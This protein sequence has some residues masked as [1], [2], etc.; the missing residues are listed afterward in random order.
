[1][2]DGVIM[3]S[4]LY[5]SDAFEIVLAPMLWLVSL[6]SF[7]ITG[8]SSGIGRATALLF[9]KHKYQLSLTGRNEAALKDVAKE[10]VQQG[11]TEN[12]LVIS[13]TDLAADDAPK[14]VVHNTLGK[15]QRIDSLVN[16]AG[17]LRAGTVLDSDI[18]VYD[19]LFNVNVRC[20]VRL[21]R[22]ALPHIIKSKGTVVNV[23]SINGPC[24]FPGVTYYCM[25]KSAVD[26]FTKCLALEMAPHGVRVNAV[27]PG[28][29]VTNLHRRSGQDE[30]AYAA[31]LEKS[32]STHALGRPGDPR[33]VAEAIL[34]LASAKS[35]FTTGQLLRVDGGASSG[36][37]QAVS[38]RLA[39]EGYALSLSGRD[40]KAL[41]ETVEQCN[42]AGAERVIIT[43]GDL[44]D[45]SNAER[46]VDNTMKE[47]QRIDTLVNSAGILVTGNV[48]DADL[49]LY[50]RQMDVNVRS[51][52]R[53]TRMALPHII[54]SKGTVVSVSSITGP[55]PFPGVTYYCMSKAALDQFTKCLALEMAPHGV[56]VNAV[57]P[58]VIVTNVHKRAGMDDQSYREFLEKGKSTHA[59]GRVGE[60]CEVA[61]AV[62]FLASEKSSFTTGELLRVDGGR[63]IMHP[64]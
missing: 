21:T 51:V 39:R 12:D 31:F 8:A 29:T 63:G 3:V 10:C 4:V 48:L 24:P 50:D 35:S 46:L 59:L 62:F 64:R 38:V 61:E 33:E 27:N 42:N 20:L 43:V 49:D 55:C 52:V 1:M 54:K 16:S 6:M 22:E 34:F 14:T 32:K 45:D 57:N 30:T 7:S 17:I 56:R 23:S 53:L 11:I 19:E 47:Y 25:S 28:V 60:A 41:M 40:E 9:A 15:F 2:T 44:C 37:G 13:P 26:Q 5:K 18:S 58:G 36:I